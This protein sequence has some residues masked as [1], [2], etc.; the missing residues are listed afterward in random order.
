MMGNSVERHEN[1]M[2]GSYTEWTARIA[3]G[4]DPDRSTYHDARDSEGVPVEVKACKRRTSR[5]DPGKYFI[6]EA[7]HEKLLDAGGLYV[8][9]V[10]DPRMWKQGPILELEM[11]SARWL[12]SVDYGWTRNGSRRGEVVKRPPWT[13]VFAREDIPGEPGGSSEDPTVVTS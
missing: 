2:W 11:K 8:F 10:Y 1:E 7:N 12:D 4:L 6:R 5:G 13:A 3:F 9:I